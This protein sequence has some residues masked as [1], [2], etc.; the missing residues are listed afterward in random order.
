M[1]PRPSCAICEG[2][3]PTRRLDHD[4]PNF[5]MNTSI[6]SLIQAQTPKRSASPD[7]VTPI[8]LHDSISH[9]ARQLWS[10]LCDG[11]SA[12]WLGE[13]GAQGYDQ[14]DI[15]TAFATWSAALELALHEPA[16][17]SDAARVLLGLQERQA[18]IGRNRRIYSFTTPQENQHRYWPTGARESI[19]RE[20][21]YTMNLCPTK[22]PVITPT[23]KIMSAGSCFAFEIGKAL[24]SW[25]YNY[26]VTEN[27]PEHLTDE[28][29]W[30][31]HYGRFA[32]RY[33]PLFNAPSIR[34][35]VERGLGLTELQPYIFEQ[36][37]V[38]RDPYRDCL[39]FSSPDEYAS[40][41]PI[42]TQALQRALLEAEIFILT[43]GVNEVW[44]FKHDGTYLSRVPWKLSPTLLGKKVLSVE[45][46]TTELQRLNDVWLKRNPH[47]RIIIT[48]SPIPLLATFRYEESNV[49]AANCHS[50][51]ILRVAAEEFARCNE[52]V[53]YFPA[54]EAVL[55]GTR[56]PFREDG[57]HVTQEAV[58]RVMRMFR[59]TFCIEV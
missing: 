36:D 35:L 59:E 21:L 24:R 25:N 43:L 16:K 9:V 57:R 6:G 45:E 19:E 23:T 56:Q 11:V 8:D 48:V 58:D 52:N 51:S 50:K 17:A 26:F 28:E 14:V 2:C 54:Y 15:D 29:R 47:L 18:E 7:A 13:V 1:K 5:P 34:Q 44:Y 3:N 46:N 12:P 31:Q 33:G 55:Y 42:F 38:W 20:N 39:T 49:V 37:G 10:V 27:G 40:S 22:D 53:V 4:R 30:D 32:A 41:I